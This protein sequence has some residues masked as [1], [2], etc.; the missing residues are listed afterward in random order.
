ML[1]FLQAEKVTDVE[2][3][4]RILS[5]YRNREVD[6]KFDFNTIKANLLDAEARNGILYVK[7]TWKTGGTDSGLRRAEHMYN[8]LRGKLSDIVR[9]KVN[10]DSFSGVL[11]STTELPEG[12]DF[13]RYTDSPF[14]VAFTFDSGDQNPKVAGGSGSIVGMGVPSNIAEQLPL[15]DDLEYEPHITVAYFPDLEKKDIPLVL[16][17]CQMAAKKTGTISAYTDGSKTFPTPAD[18]GTYPL[19]ADVNSKELHKFHDEL[20]TL[21]ERFSPGLAD[22]TFAHKNYNPH[23]T[24]KYVTK[25]NVS[26]PVKRLAWTT[27]QLYLSFKGGEEFFPIPLRA[28]M[29]IADGD[30]DDTYLQVGEVKVPI[31]VVSNDNDELRLRVKNGGQATLVDDMEGLQASLVTPKSEMKMEIQETREMGP[32]GFQVFYRPLITYMS[33]DA[34]SRLRFVS[35]VAR[36]RGLSSVVNRIGKL[37]DFSDA[38]EEE[39]DAEDKEALG[40]GSPGTDPHIVTYV[41]APQ[42]QQIVEEPK[43]TKNMPLHERI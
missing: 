1:R 34:A 11:G 39:D 10:V 6:L 37:L 17:C 32:D 9:F 31:I 8:Y 12:A 27:D 36:D 28:D 29:R 20:I 2:S 7:F 18:D 24:L 23:V 3:A 25:S 38:G 43:F 22:T 35:A 30:M 16:K 33:R 15:A 5:K 40:P 21:L 41:K 19:V 4:A 13:K 42:T 14:V 26:L